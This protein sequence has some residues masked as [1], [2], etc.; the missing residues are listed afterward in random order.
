MRAALCYS[1]QQFLPSSSEGEVF[2]I[3]YIVNCVLNACLSYVAVVLNILTI[4]AMLATPS[5]PK[6]L[7]TLLM[8]LAVSDLAVGLLGQP[9][10]IALLVIA[11]LQNTPSCATNTAFIITMN[12]F[13]AAS[14]LT[15][16]ALSAD[17]FLA[18][19]LHLRYQELVTHNRVAAVV[20]SI[21][22]L[23]GAFYPLAFSY[24]H[25]DTV[26]LMFVTIGSTCL[27]V[28]SLMFLK[29]FSVVRR[30]NSQ[31]QSQLQ[32]IAQISEAANI[33]NGRKTAM[34]IFYVYLVFLVCYLPQ[35]CALTNIIIRGH[36]LAT[37]HLLISTLTLVF[38][39]SSLNPVIYCWK[40]RYIRHAIMDTLCRILQRRL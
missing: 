5:L 14:F 39:N 12:V 8:S 18:I 15:V 21:W 2:H 38:L 29:I 40:L 23:C 1:L 36:S 27:I 30:H 6:S 7:R 19:H 13:C 35:F 10:Y 11:L 37:K 25:P 24:V 4:R 34:G 17:R 3:S 31:I 9:F 20:I 33:V 26:H 22:V 16:I 28:A 32:H